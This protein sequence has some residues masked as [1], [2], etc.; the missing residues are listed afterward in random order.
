MTAD[1]TGTTGQAQRN[2]RRGQA[3]ALSLACALLL[4][5]VC[6]FAGTAAAQAGYVGILGGGP[7]Y[8]HVDQNIGE[9]KKSGFNELIVWSVEVNSSGDLNLNGEFPLTSAG[10]Y[11]GNQTYPDFRKDLAKMR[12][13]SVTRVTFSIGSSNYGDWE[14]IAALVNSQGTGPDSILYQDFAALKQ[15]LPIDAIDFDDEN[16]YDAPTTIKFALMLRKLGYHVTMDPYTNSSYWTSVVSQINAKRAGT[17]DAIHLQTY[18]GGNGNT[19]CQANW[20]FGDVPVYPGLS[21]QTSAP[22]YKTPPEA[23]AILRTW[24]KTCGIKGGWLWIFDQIAG[25][26]KV[27]KYAHDMTAGVG[28]RAQ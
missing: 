18:A 2:A 15:A 10:A 25:T 21:D 6:A 8:K 19:P 1:A 28:D 22:P 16:G 24:H 20:N 12:R 3:R 13:G 4:S 27:R 5:G 9:L 26:D 23:K 7:V 17:V 11:V 14:D